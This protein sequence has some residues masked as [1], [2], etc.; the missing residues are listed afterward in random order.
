MPRCMRGEC[1]R[2]AAGLSALRA[3]AG[4]A[5]AGQRPRLVARGLGAARA[6]GTIAKVVDD[7]VARG[8]SPAFIRVVA[9]VAA[10]PALKLLSEKFPG[11]RP[12]M[13]TQPRVPTAASRATLYARGV[14]TSCMGAARPVPHVAQPR[15]PHDP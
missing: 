13:R 8:A 12:R 4:T 9:V 5:L 3:R 1:A 2:P 15:G 6:G 7:L 14:K 10:P 11:A